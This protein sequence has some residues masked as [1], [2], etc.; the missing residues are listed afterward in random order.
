MQCV[1]AFVYL[2]HI[3]EIGHS[4]QDIPKTRPRVA[5]AV[6]PGIQPLAHSWPHQNPIASLKRAFLTTNYQLLHL[7]VMFYGRLRFGLLTLT[8]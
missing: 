5:A 6:A 1:I 7:L 2:V 4:C 3:A 8:I